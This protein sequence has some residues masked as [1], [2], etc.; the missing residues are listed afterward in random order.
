MVEW[1]DGWMVGW[2]D[3]RTDG[4]RDREREREREREKVSVPIIESG[5]YKD[6]MLVTNARSRVEISIQA[7]CV[8]LK[9]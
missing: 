1:M 2:T 9:F 8:R 3:K 7:K 4:D 6:R 5:W